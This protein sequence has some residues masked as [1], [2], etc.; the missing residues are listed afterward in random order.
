MEEKYWVVVIKL[1]GVYHEVKTYK[2]K[3]NAIDLR[4]KLRSNKPLEKYE[5][6][7]IKM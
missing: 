1:G 4:D 3:N 6:V 2:R 7:R 5:L